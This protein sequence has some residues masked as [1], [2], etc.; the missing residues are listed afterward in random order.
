MPTP[1]EYKTV[2]ARILHYA[3]EIGWRYVPRAE[4]ETRRGFD[5][6]GPTLEDRAHPATPY[7]G[8]LLHAQVCAFNPKY[9]EAEGALVGEFR[10]LNADIAGN[11]DFLAYL[12][13]KGKFFSADENRELDLTLID[14]GD[15]TR[16]REHWRNV[17][18]VTEEFY[19]HNGHYGTREDV[20][21]LIN[22]IPVLV[23]ECKNATKNEAIA[24]GVD[25]IRR[26]HV[27][28]PE[29]MV[30]E[31]IFT[32]TEAIG[33]AYGVTWSTVRRNIFNWKHEEVGNLEAKVKSFCA[34]P[35]LLRFLRD[36]IIFAEKEEELQKVILRQHQ[37]AAVDRVVARALDPKR[38]RGLVWHTQG[39]GKTYTMIKAA[40]LL[41]KAN[42]AQKPTI[43]L[44]I[45]RNELEDQLLKNLAAVG[46]A[47][48]AHADRITTLNKLL[49]EK[50]QDYRG[51]VVTMIHK[52]RDMPANLNLRKNIFVLIDEAHRTTGGD[53]G[54]FLMAGLPNASFIGFTGTPV[55]KTVYGKGTFKTFGCEDD[56]GYLH[57]YSISE[58]IQDGTT[59][60]LYYNLAPNQML[61]PHEIMEK[62]FFSLAET[63]GIADIEE[64]NKILERA[65]NLKNFLKGK[66]RVQKVARYVADHYRENVEPL[67][68]KAFLVAV[69]REA[70]TFYK[71]ALDAILPPEYSEIVFTGTN[72]D[73][74][75]L[76]KWHIDE[77]KEKQIRKTFIKVGDFPKI[78]IV[79][80]KLLTGFDAPILYAMYLDKP[81]RDHTLLQAIARVNRPYE[82]ESAE[83]V[84]PHGFV[85]DFV[86]IFD[87]LEKAL[88]FD[89]DEI[90]AIVKD[91]GLL[92][93]LFRAK[94]ETKTP[95]YLSLVSRKFDDK[96]VDNLIEHFRDKDRREEFF[97]EYKE[98]EMLYEI[99]SPDAFLRPFID[100]YATLSSIYAVVR[101]AYAKKVYVDKAFQ[102]KTNELVQKH[103]GVDQLQNVSEFVKIDAETV[104]LIKKQMGGD[105][106]KVIN[107]IKSI[108]KTAEDNSGDPFLIAMA[109][110]AQ[111]VLELFEDRQTSTAD[112]LADLLKEIEKDE[113]RKKEQ[114]AKGLDGLT[115][116]VLC[117]L[118]DDGIPNPNPTAKKIADAF[119]KFPN[120][121]R[122]ETELRETRKQ[123][124]FAIF[125]EEDDMQKVTVTVESLFTL[126]QKSFK[127]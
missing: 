70:C 60:P 82:V 97:K 40:E 57:K 119:A 34:V 88:A 104:E 63:E 11:R 61:V 106:T 8:D 101:N 85:L 18:E 94:M 110:R 117:K 91:I 2:Q 77:K 122:S 115:Y 50:G 99:I 48:V 10:L 41:F 20:V 33:F 30:P 47:N 38:S 127:P 49:D 87:K 107:L 62:E 44:M 95:P 65:V 16:P 24:L 92:K 3:Q 46:M 76:K 72:N 54:N 66:D 1:G 103:I 59:L 113:R 68:Y 36:F 29:V 112:A 31:M 78:L 45:D 109:E 64:L 17:Y 116:F 67:G 93:Q 37:T 90:N 118:T 98:I 73:P 121:Q 125:A 42:E 51:I 126:L 25:Q 9:R 32:A 6:D 35:H 124:T 79:T 108:Q 13:N 71:E 5:A 7:F 27:E 14:Y 89:S 86:G 80:E 19:V 114:V 96:D 74:P 83:L 26:Y 15:L 120:W 102:K 52:F 123:V 111:A 105:G 58:S 100:D 21:F 39:S 12:R 23:I 4:A 28:T 22:G 84:K 69:D 56:K 81:M 43:L 53:L 75:H 55:D